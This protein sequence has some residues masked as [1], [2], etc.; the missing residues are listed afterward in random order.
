MSEEDKDYTSENKRRMLVALAIM[1]GASIEASP[2]SWKEVPKEIQ[3]QA[4][5]YYEERG[6]SRIAEL[7]T[8]LP[9]RE[10]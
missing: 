6:L 5:L 7:P 10:V 8:R 2:D 1:L 4:K 9:E 3:K